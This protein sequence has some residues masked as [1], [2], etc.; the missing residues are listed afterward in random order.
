MLLKD[1]LVRQKNNEKLAIKYGN[2]SVS[3]KEL[4]ETAKRYAELIK[5]YGYVLHNIGIFLPNSI[6]YVEAYFSITFLD[7]VI[8]PIGVM[9][10]KAEVRSTVE[11]CELGMIITDSKNVE[12][13]KE[14]L[15]GFEYKVII[16][17]IENGCFYE[18]GNKVKE[19]VYSIC[20]SSLSE[21]SVALLLHTSG[22]TSNPKR[23]ML[24]HGNLLANVKSIIESFQ[25]TG[26]DKCL[27]VTP[28][29]FAAG[30]TRLMLTHLY[31]GASMIV[32]EG[33]FVASKF[34]KLVQDEEITNLFMV[35]T[36]LLMLLNYK[37]KSSFDTSSL[38]F[39]CFGGGVM[40]I[41]KLKD[42]LNTFRDIPFV[43]IYGQ[44]EASPRISHL[45]PEDRFKK[46]GSVGKA[47]PGV[48]LRIVDDEG[49]DV[50]N[51]EPG[52]IIVQGSNVMKGYYNRPDETKK[53]IKDE[54]LYTGDLGKYDEEGFVYITGRKKNVI[55]SNGVNIYPE[56]IEEVLMRHS[57]IKE[58]CVVGE[59]HSIL[60]EVPIAK[61]ILN[62]Q[63]K[64]IPSSGKL[65]NLEVNII[66]FC[67]EKLTAYKIPNRI[68]F[69]TNLE[70]TSSG[71]IK[72]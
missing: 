34:F 70:K 26:T 28:M 17:N 27:T 37:N 61:V 49:C 23:V 60:G 48:T 11:Y 46:V 21:D 32:M 68:D 24:T 36:M 6:R 1:I 19:F 35:P 20:E 14:F 8:V 57:L 38:K 5:D 12:A 53:V 64:L 71:K 59:E 50:S 2:T 66:N 39:V 72:R 41:N 7:R 15:N 3:Y 40:P 30:N 63:T 62:S 55:I 9:A 25:L 47:I 44:T 51:G 4:Y 18:V 33:R 22:T 10:K 67:F 52:E 16:F 54:W 29:F 45:T 65:K 69:V 58:V 56:E 13:L 43:Q 42:L 31:L